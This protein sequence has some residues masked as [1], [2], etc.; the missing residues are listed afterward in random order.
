MGAH[1]AAI[2]NMRAIEHHRPHADQY[3]IAQRAAMQNHAVTYGAILADGERIAHIRVENAAF[4][5]IGTRP[6]IYALIVAAQR[7]AKPDIGPCTQPHIAD[8]IGVR[9][10]PVRAILRQ[11]GRA[12]IQFI[13]GHERLTNLRDRDREWPSGR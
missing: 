1:K 13:Q 6:D 5:N 10:N 11:F 2:G 8:D 12:A 7:R 3:A 4:L 9:R